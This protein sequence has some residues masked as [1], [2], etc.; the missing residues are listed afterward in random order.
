MQVSNRQKPHVTIAPER[1]VLLLPS[2]RL[3][4]Q[5][6]FLYK[7]IHKFHHKW[8]A[9]CATATFYC[10][11]LEHYF[12]NLAPLALG[13]ILIGAHLSTA[14]LWYIVSLLSTT[15][16]HS[17]YHF[18]FLPSSEAHDYHHKKSV[19]MWCSVATSSCTRCYISCVQ[20]RWI[21][22]NT[23]CVQERLAII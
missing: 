19:T 4:H 20:E 3:L 13:P 17:G 23:S 21:S 16:A 12:A 2:C 5:T 8:T 18:P 1:S 14:W 9:P 6:P 10:H 15:V 22:Y 7:H 11:P